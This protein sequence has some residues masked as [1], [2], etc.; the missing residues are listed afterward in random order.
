MNEVPRQATSIRR[1]LLI[2]LLPPLLLLMLI[3]VYVNYRA[4]TSFVRAAFDQRLAD[5]ARMLGAHLQSG[6]ALLSEQASPFKYRIT[7]SDGQVVAGDPRLPV[8][9][10]G[11]ADLSY[12]DARFDGHSLRFRG[13][14]SLLL[15]GEWRIMASRFLD[16]SVFYDAGKVTARRSDL[17]FNG[18]KHDY[19]FGLRFHG[20]I[21][22]PLRLEL[23]RGSDGVQLVISTS[24]VF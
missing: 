24:A 2:F 20:P 8:P 12:A 19:G 9:P 13:E 14:N 4:A 18:L 21:S 10:P 17:D 1:R 5:T 16:S 3:G 22:T 6:P 11:N 7:A 23:A 15:Q